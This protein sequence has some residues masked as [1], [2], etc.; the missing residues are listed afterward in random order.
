MGLMWKIALPVACVAHV[1]VFAAAPGSR[2]APPRAPV[3][4][5]VELRPGAFA[6]R[7][8]GEF[9]RDGKP[10]P[11]PLATVTIARPLAI[12]RHQV[13]AADY[14]RCVDD[15]A[16]A[17]ADGEPA[18]DR[19]VVKVNW[20]DAHA[21]AAWL[22]RVAAI[23]F[24]LPTDEEWAYA[25]ADRRTDDALPEIAYADPGR[26]ALAQY[27]TDAG[28]AASDRELRPLGHFGINASGLADMAGNVWEWT[29]TCFARVMLDAVGQA[30]ATLTN[31]GVRIAAGRHRSYV[32]DFIRDARGGGCSAGAQPS[33]LGFRLVRDDG[34][35]RALRF[36]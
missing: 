36:F 10:A 23:R 14:R 27:D 1:A 28:R 15:G 18:P 11:A 32:P 21:Y 25:A 19:P 34:P 31:C 30:A 2:P 22:S 5:V 35:P 7:A 24:R 20:R 3:P 4:E 13:T 9:S 6:Y 33:N 17:T 26:R 16:C 12:M 29:D 8:S